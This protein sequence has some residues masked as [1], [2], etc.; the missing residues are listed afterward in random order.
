MRWLAVV[1]LAAAVSQAA[2]VESMS[3]EQ[4]TASATAVVRVAVG[5]ARTSRSGP[6]IFTDY[7]LRVVETMAGDAEG[8]GEVSLPGGEYEGVSQ[9]FSGVPELG[10]GQQ[11]VLFLWRGPSGRIQVVGLAQGVFAVEGETA[12]QVRTAG[13][14]SASLSALRDRLG[15]AGRKAAATP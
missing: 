7:R 15:K 10:V 1:G 8:I 5:E 12:T 4:M 3:I 13:G 2:M 11:Y 6:L 14:E 9:A